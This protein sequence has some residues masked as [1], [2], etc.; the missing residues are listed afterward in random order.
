MW[1]SS[2]ERG[3]GINYYSRIILIR[4]L[5][6]IIITVSVVISLL[7]YGFLFMSTDY[8]SRNV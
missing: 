7:Y 3:T 4:I 2:V 5:I 1:W 8:F 6:I